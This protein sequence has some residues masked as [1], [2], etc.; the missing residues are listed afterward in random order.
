M[1]K[2]LQ[3]LAPMP[4]LA[5]NHRFQTADT[6]IDDLRGMQASDAPRGKICASLLELYKYRNHLYR[7]AKALG[8]VTSAQYRKLSPKQKPAVKVYAVLSHNRKGEEIKVAIRVLDKK[9]L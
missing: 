3:V 2:K 6:V 4:E 8:W 9:T 7:A 1:D 5:T